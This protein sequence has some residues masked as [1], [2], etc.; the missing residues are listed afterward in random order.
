MVL[1]CH[2]RCH[3]YGKEAVH[4]NIKTMLKLRRY[5]QIKA[6]AEQGWTEDEFRRQF[7]KSYLTQQDIDN[8]GESIMLNKAILQGR[9]VADAEMRRTQS[10]K[11]V[12]S[13][14]IACDRSFKSKD[15]NAQNADFINI[16]AWGSTADFISKYFSKGSMILIEGRIQA[17][18]Y[19]DN[20]GQRRY[21]TEVV[22]ES[23]NFAGSKKDSGGTGGNYNPPSNSYGQNQGGYSGYQYPPDVSAEGFE[24]LNDDDG[25]L[26]F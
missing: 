11:S 1:L 20:N 3:L 9:L 4:N 25:E 22:A 16:L 8:R 15:P 5:A 2:A 10:G 12:A 21:V 26:P 13:F 7:G 18:S 6:M 14:R 19:D 23:V 24:E 17:R